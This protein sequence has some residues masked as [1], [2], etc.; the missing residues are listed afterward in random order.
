[1]DQAGSIGLL[2]ELLQEIE[3]VRAD[4]NKL[5]AWQLKCQTS[6]D[7]IFGQQSAQLARLNGVK[8][9]FYGAYNIGENTPHISAF[10][11]GI[12]KAKEI[13]K[14]IIW[15]VER[16]GP[17]AAQSASEPRYALATVELVCASF[18]AVACQ[19]RNRRESRPTLDVSDEYDVQDLLHALL[20]LHFDDIRAEE[21]TPSYAGSSAR[22]DFLLKNEGIV[23]EVK[24][25]RTGLDAKKVGEQLIIDIAHYR[26][27]SGCRTLICFV[28]DPENRITNPAG[29]GRDLA[30]E[31]DDFTAK[32]IVAPRT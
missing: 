20:R 25:T 6:L 15:E 19:L 26:A 32:V 30:I 8:Y 22:M 12:D 7:R 17:P 16:F 10:N 23:I 3:G 21:W 28:Y 24:K 2:N 14:A 5:G 29:L 27:H 18:H 13:L 9:R 1:M 11:Q 4:S 31:D